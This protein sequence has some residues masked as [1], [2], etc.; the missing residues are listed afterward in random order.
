MDLPVTPYKWQFQP[1]TGRAAGAR[2]DYGSVINW[3]SAQGPLYERIRNVNQ[4][5]NLKDEM[6]ELRVNP[7][8]AQSFNQWRPEQIAQPLGTPHIP[9]PIVGYATVSDLVQTRDGAQLSGPISGGALYSPSSYQLGDGRQYRKLTRDNH[10]FPH[11][12][13][14][15]ENGKWSPIEMDGGFSGILKWFPKIPDFPAIMKYRRPGQ[16]LQGTGV[17]LNPKSYLLLSEQATV[18]RSGGMTSNQFMYEFPPVVYNDPFSGSLEN[19][20]K[21]FNPLFDPQTSYLRSNVNTLQYN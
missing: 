7:E 20:P 12:W 4:A 10:P 13:M 11:N 19:F 9:P 3:F 6:N 2:Q 18:P 14:V 8:M 15:L 5:R 21:E 16:Q 1:E 17:G